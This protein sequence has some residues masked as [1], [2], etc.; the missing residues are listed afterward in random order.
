METKKSTAK[1]DKNPFNRR[2][3]KITEKAF[4]S[5]NKSVDPVS[6]DTNKTRRKTTRARIVGETI[7]KVKPISNLNKSMKKSMKGKC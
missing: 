7:E 6:K 3:D 5:V 2:G 1:V 4:K